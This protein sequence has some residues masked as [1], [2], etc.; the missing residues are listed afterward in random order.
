MGT[1]ANILSPHH[2]VLGVMTDFM[3]LMQYM[4]GSLI[5][6]EILNKRSTQNISAEPFIR[7]FLVS[8]LCF[9]YGWILRDTTRIYTGL[10]KILIN[11][12][13]LTIYASFLDSKH[14][15]RKFTQHFNYALTITAICM[16]YS[17]YEDPTL[18]E[19]R[20]RIFVG[21]ILMASPLFHLGEIIRKKNSS[22]H[23]R[24]IAMGM[25]VLF[26]W[27]IYSLATQNPFLITQNSAGIVFCLLQILSLVFLDP[28]NR[29]NQSL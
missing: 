6:C 4:S 2:D 26:L 21:F 10:V 15:T 16:G 8:I 20:Y 27:L 1:I 24:L 7:G 23:L 29:E 22:A 12:L 28:N 14:Q 18:V 5:C 25:I 9:H 17:W 11:L 13:Y 3:T 19:F